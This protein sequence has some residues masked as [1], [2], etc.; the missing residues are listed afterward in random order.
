VACKN[1][2]ADAAL[3]PRGMKLRVEPMRER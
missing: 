1:L 3:V 2:P